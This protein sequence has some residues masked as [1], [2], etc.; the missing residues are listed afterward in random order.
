LSKFHEQYNGCAVVGIE[1]IDAYSEGCMIE[2]L[3]EYKGLTSQEWIAS[4]LGRSWPLSSL[5]RVSHL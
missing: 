1:G 4:T 2:S 3:N 5:L